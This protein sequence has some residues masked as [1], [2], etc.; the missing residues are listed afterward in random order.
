MQKLKRIISNWYKQNNIWLQEFKKSVFKINLSGKIFII[1][2]DTKTINW[3]IP[4]VIKT[5]LEYKVVTT[6]IFLQQ[7]LWLFIGIGIL[8]TIVYVFDWLPIIWSSV[9]TE[10]G[11][12]HKALAQGTFDVARELFGSIF[13]FLKVCR[14][15]FLSLFI[16]LPPLH[17]EI[18][19]SF[20]ICTY[21]KKQLGDSHFCVPTPSAL[22]YDPKTPWTGDRLCDHWLE[23][24]RLKERKREL[25]QLQLRSKMINY[26][27]LA[28]VS[29][30]L[31][32]ASFYYLTTMTDEVTFTPLTWIISCLQQSNNFEIFPPLFEFHDQSGLQLKP[33]ISQVE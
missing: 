14:H 24:I 22:Q 15:H 12:N 23:Q 11:L 32:C 31:F 29:I 30:I 28:G 17:K 33:T 27:L 4:I 26:W 9:L 25:A 3:G 5:V 8:S 2:K 16:D 7:K 21:G 13:R 6:F 19:N 10:T 18:Q 1:K 20:D